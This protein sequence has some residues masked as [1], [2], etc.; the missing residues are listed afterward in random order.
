[1]LDVLFA[2]G[3][4]RK[5]T[6]QDYSTVL[7]KPRMGVLSCA[8]WEPATLSIMAVYGLQVY[9]LKHKIPAK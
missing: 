2:T 5:N 1:M 8:I 6:M 7:R 9:N 3:A 4:E